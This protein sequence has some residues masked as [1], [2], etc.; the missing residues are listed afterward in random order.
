MI[1]ETG[2]DFAGYISLDEVAMVLAKMRSGHGRKV[3]PT[4]VL[5][6][7]LELRGMVAKK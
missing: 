2:G 4:V 5:P 1:D 3:P 6:L 7:Y